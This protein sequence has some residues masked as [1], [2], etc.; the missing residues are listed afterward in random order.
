[1]AKI[2]ALVTAKGIMDVYS[3]WPFYI[4]IVIFCMA[5]IQPTKHR[6]DGEVVDALVN[7]VHVK[8]ERFSYHIVSKA[9]RSD[10][11]MND[12]YYK[13]TPDRLDQTAEHETIQENDEAAL[14]NNRIK[15][16]QLPAKGKGQ[17]PAFLGICKE[18]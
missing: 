8:D 7:I 17:R 13:P 1:M 18:F 5:D 12:L 4:A 6:K 2:H 3:R 10:S 9:T 16:V 14:K 15:D 11:R